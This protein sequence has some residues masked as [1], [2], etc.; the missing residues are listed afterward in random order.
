MTAPLRTLR[1]V[2]VVGIGWHRYQHASETSY[3]TLGLTAIRAAL[4]DAKLEWSQVESSYIGTARL[5]MAAGRAMLRHLGH[6]GQP[7]VHI[8]NASA[9][10]SAATADEGS[11]PEGEEIADCG[12][13]QE[14]GSGQ[15]DP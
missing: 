13:R 3:V 6:Q 12:K 5:G 2:Y 15:P 9:S 1:P 11:E 10:G 7:L 14:C 8:E 4:A